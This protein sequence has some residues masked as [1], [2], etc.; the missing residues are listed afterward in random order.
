[1]LFEVIKKEGFTGCYA[2][3]IESVRNWR[4]VIAPQVVSFKCAPTIQGSYPSPLI[5]AGVDPFFSA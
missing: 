5:L 3:V 1:M 2:R 4:N